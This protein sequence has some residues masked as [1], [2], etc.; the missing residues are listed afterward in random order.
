MRT[1]GQV[2][3][4]RKAADGSNDAAGIVRS[5]SSVR[6]IFSRWLQHSSSENLSQALSRSQRVDFAVCRQADFNFSFRPLQ[7]E[8]RVRKSIGFRDFDSKSL[9]EYPFLPSQTEQ[10]A[11]GFASPRF[12]SET[13]PRYGTFTDDDG[14]TH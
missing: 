11:P 10:A 9:H 6:Q 14:I 8:S 1:V 3:D 4:C 12:I 2:T 5:R 13:R 7:F